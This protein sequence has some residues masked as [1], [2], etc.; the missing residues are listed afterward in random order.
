MTRAGFERVEP[1]RPGI[2]GKHVQVDGRDEVVQVDLIVPESL[3]GPGRRGAR[4][5]GH[6]KQAAG[7]AD[8][9]EA[10]VVDR[11]PT[12][13]R[14][15]KAADT[16]STTID[17]AG[18]TALLIAKLHKL[19]DRVSE[20][21]RLMLHLGAD[22][23]VTRVRYLLN[24]PIASAATER[25]LEYLRSLFYAPGLAGVQ[26]A[27][28]GLASDLPSDRVEAVCVEFTRSVLERI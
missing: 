24:E 15:Y 26:L 19:S 2:W 4:L 11:S 1:D 6:S 9:L 7:R 14:S 20:S 3:A 28:E 16:K 22:T 23:A 17:V 5:S 8:G 18:P 12:E 21:D 10:A 27:V 25:A 13:I